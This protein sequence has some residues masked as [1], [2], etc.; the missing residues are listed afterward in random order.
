MKVPALILATALVAPAAPG[1][2]LRCGKWIVNEETPLEELVSKCGQPRSKEIETQ[3]IRRR[4]GN[5]VGTQVVGT[6]TVEKWIYRRTP[7][8]LPMRV[9]IEDGKVKRIERAE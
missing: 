2:D 9:T 5:G 3:E 8:S 1:D 6:T 7:G 4:N